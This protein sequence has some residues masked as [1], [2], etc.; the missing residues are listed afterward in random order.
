MRRTTFTSSLA[1]VLA[2]SPLL[3][4]EQLAA[5]EAAPPPNLSE[6]DV[7]SRLDPAF[8]RKL[9]TSVQPLPSG[10]VGPNKPGFDQVGVQNQASFMVPAAVLGKDRTLL[11]DALRVL[12]YGF[13]H[14]NS[15]GSFEYADRGQMGAPPVE[16]TKDASAGFFLADVGRSLRLLDA[17]SW[18]KSDPS[19]AG[20]RSRIQAMQVKLAPALAKLVSQADVLRTDRLAVN[21]TLDYALAYYLNGRILSQDDALTIGREFS[22]N[23]LGRETPDGVF[24]ESGGFDSSYQGVSLT[25][26]QVLFF[27]L[28]P[29]DAALRARLWPA[30][31]LAANRE[32]AAVGDD[33]AVRV[34]GNSRV[35]THGESV[36]GKVKSVDGRNVSLGLMYYAYS[37]DSAA[38][39]SIAQKV[40][41]H[42]AVL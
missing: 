42:Y 40:A 4:G 20:E 1:S 5:A 39:K 24:P 30:I 22:A 3:F 21:R 9:A 29:A 18:F 28:L 19:V 12:E 23:V 15:D 8:L 6:L 31:V 11:G 33:G 7:L 13:A 38:L 35:G 27:E 32:I 25:L 26:A 34:E 41:V 17:S 16:L 2:V 36:F 10:A 37:T 14:M